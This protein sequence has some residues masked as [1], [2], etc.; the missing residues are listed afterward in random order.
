MGQKKAFV[1]QLQG[2]TFTVK[3]DS[4]HWV[5]GGANPKDITLSNKMSWV[6]IS[7][8]VCRSISILS[9]YLYFFSG[10]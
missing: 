10:I 3:T 7:K 6:K 5:K 2:I 1:K 4:N 9:L 8:V